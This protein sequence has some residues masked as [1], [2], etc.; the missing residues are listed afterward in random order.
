[1]R[2]YLFCLAESI[3]GDD[4]VLRIVVGMCFGVHLTVRTVS[5]VMNFTTGE[6]GRSCELEENSR[7]VAGDRLSGGSA[8]DISRAEINY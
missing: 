1:M 3:I 5:V 6:S 4:D 2:I 8:I 7:T